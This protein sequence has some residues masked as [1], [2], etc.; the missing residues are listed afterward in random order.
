M[1]ITLLNRGNEIQKLMLQI[2]VRVV[3]HRQVIT[4][5]CS[6][7]LDYTF[8]VFISTIIEARKR[9]RNISW[10]SDDNL[11][12]EIDSSR[13]KGAYYLVL[14]LKEDKRAEPWKAL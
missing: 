1:Q 13:L 10:S 5:K 9:P 4:C 3:D 6:L 14:T 12:Q 7:T 8:N 2:M 11:N